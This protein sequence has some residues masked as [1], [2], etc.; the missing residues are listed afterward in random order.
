MHGRLELPY[1]TSRTG[2]FICSSSQKYIVWV[3]MLQVT[4]IFIYS[5]TFYSNPILFSYLSLKKKKKKT[6]G[7]QHLHSLFRFLTT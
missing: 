2:I 4:V 6:L 7:L 3:K 1:K 5:N